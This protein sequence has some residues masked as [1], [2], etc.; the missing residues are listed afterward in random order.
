MNEA[1]KRINKCIKNGSKRLDLSN[2]KLKE[3]PPLPDNLIK[4]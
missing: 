4:L 2:L 3:L 1:R